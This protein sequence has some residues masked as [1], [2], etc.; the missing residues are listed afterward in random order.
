MASGRAERAFLSILCGIAVVTASPPIAFAYA[1]VGEP[2]SG[3]APDAPSPTRAFSGTTEVAAPV[4]QPDAASGVANDPSTDDEA[5]SRPDDADDAGTPDA[6]GAD[7]TTDDEGVPERLTTMQ[8]AGWWTIFGAVAVGTL[9]GVM[10][11]LAERQE[12]RAL[13]LSVRFE[14]ATGAQSRYADVQGEYESAL[15]RGRA[16]AGAGIGLAVVGL[17]ALVAGVTVLGVASA[18]AK[19]DRPPRSGAR[20]Q[21][22]GSGMQVRF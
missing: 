10:A 7:E 9:A 21:W 3:E 15:R 18:R 5:P 22:R 14:L 19:R 1:P 4:A 13:R 6:P 8:A 12:D 2:V 17:A 16:H 20:M 11:G